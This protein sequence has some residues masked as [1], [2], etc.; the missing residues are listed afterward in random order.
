MACDVAI[1][2]NS[3]FRKKLMTLHNGHVLPFHHLLFLSQRLWHVNEPGRQWFDSQSGFL[4]YIPSSTLHQT[5]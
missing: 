2:R 1:P 4:K 5:I 3:A